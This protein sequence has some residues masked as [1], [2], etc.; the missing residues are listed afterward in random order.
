[1]Y[2]IGRYSNF[3]DIKLSKNLSI[4][5]LRLLG[6]AIDSSPSPLTLYDTDYSIIYANEASR[7]LW[8][9][10]HLGLSSGKG[11][12]QSAYDAAKAV[13]PGASESELQAATQYV[14][15]TFSSQEANEMRASKGRCM[16][17]THHQI[18]DRA[19][20]G[21]GV[22]ITDLKANEKGLY[23][24]KRAQENLIEVLE[25]GLLIIND[26]G[27]VTLFNAAYKEYCHS[28]NVDVRVGMKIRELTKSFVDRRL[29]EGGEIWP[30]AWDP[31]LFLDRLGDAKTHT[32]EFDLQDGR[33]ILMRQS[34]RKL[35]GNIVTLTD[36]TKIKKAQLKAESAE[37][38][39]SEFLANMSHEIRT[40]MNGIMGMAQ[41][42][43]QCALTEKEQ[44]F[45]QIIQR[46]G[47]ALLTIIN[48]ILDFSKIEAGRV[49][50]ERVEF[51][52]SN[53]LQ[54]VVSLLSMAAADKGV[55][56]IF[57]MQPDLPEVYFGDPG[58]LRQVI[59]NI[60]GNAVKFT[61]NGH[62]FINVSGESVGDV[63]NL[64]ISIQ[65]T[66]IGISP[67]QLDVIFDKFQQ[68][69][70]SK[71]REFE[72]TGL[73]L[74]I[75]KQLINLMGG[76]IVAK[77]EIGKGSCFEVRLP[78]AVAQERN[79]PAPAEQVFAG[80]KALIIDDN[81]LNCRI[82][83]DQLSCWGCKSACVDS[84]SKGILALE[85][86]A[87]KNITIDFIIVDYQMPGETG[88]VFVQKIQAHT[89]FKS[90]PVIM[91]TSI[92][93]SAYAQNLLGQ[94][95]SACVTKPFN[96]LALYNAINSLSSP[97]KMAAPAKPSR[98][99]TA[100]IEQTSSIALPAPIA[101]VPASILNAQDRVD[102]LVAE[103]N[104]INRF[105]IEY[106]LKDL[107][108][109]YEIVNDGQLAVEAFQT[110]SPRLIL[111]DISM[112]VMNGY[113]ATQKIRAL[114]GDTPDPTPIIAITAHAME[115]D[116]Q[117]ALDSGMNGHIT[118]PL[119][120]MSI[121]KVIRKWNIIDDDGPVNISAASSA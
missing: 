6:E 36:V 86:A 19:V 89:A 25:Y 92:V 99:D 118:K 5:H 38:S 28:F 18:G 1:M 39:K 49:S 32:Q 27:V 4:E 96:H 44:N 29:L 88:D 113:Q 82:L 72:G 102:I 63:V 46:S 77:S 103:D 52:L 21:I 66:G 56:L 31:K 71:T 105:Y 57:N 94:G 16:K 62:V 54:D 60:Y 74:S 87:K 98:A 43:E 58:R 119:A 8:P 9:E 85:A 11:L 55:E 64:V 14:I 67:C 10:L 7:D 17:L 80:L 83:K 110:L 22:D 120:I 106:V 79:L 47:E 65:D 50:L 84:A 111:M 114:E 20:A 34:Y 35:V 30:N 91:L 15:F 116:R 68:V 108:V 117:R 45:V 112:P 90:I 115:E 37:R 42:L 93:E 97:A 81:P 70:G 109:T 104:E 121:K 12:E 3:M 73:G 61:R 69:D 13:F 41:L 101:L 53:S 95:V 107:G 75:A 48:D 51:N 26:E 100:P 23:R 76:D 40:P 33:H 24:A 78:L 2:R 59:T